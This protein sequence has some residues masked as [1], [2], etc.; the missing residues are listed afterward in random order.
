MRLL[1]DM[2]LTPRWVQGLA[3]AG[4]DSVHWSDIGE[5]TAPDSEICEYARRHGF[6]VMTSD[7][8]FPQI[9]AHTAAAKPSVILFR[10]EP[11]VPEMRLPSVLDAIESCADELTRGAI[12]SINWSERPRA[13]L[14][15]LA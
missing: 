14:L 8:D 2:N 13:R 1:I 15:P 12:L 3:E 7:M 9:L 10:G 6:V 4:H 11:N 5:P